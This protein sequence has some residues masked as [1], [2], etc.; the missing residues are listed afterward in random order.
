MSDLEADLLPLNE[1]PSEPE[2]S[3]EDDPTKVNRCF[4][5]C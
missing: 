2:D 4:I 1:D 5:S 3:E